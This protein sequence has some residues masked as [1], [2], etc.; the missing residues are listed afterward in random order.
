MNWDQ[1]F[2]TLARTVLVLC[3][4]WGICFCVCERTCGGVCVGGGDGGWLFVL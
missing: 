4:V 2:L 3:L 1:S